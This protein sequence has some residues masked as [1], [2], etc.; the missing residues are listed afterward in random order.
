MHMDNFKIIG[1]LNDAGYRVEFVTADK[2]E[3]LPAGPAAVLKWESSTLITRG[4][5]AA[6]AL[7][8]VALYVVK[9][10]EAKRIAELTRRGELH[11]A[12]SAELG[13]T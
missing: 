2:N 9:E 1:L 12:L 4:V 7:R 6:D 10:V 3:H 11:A 8:A 5:D 13:R